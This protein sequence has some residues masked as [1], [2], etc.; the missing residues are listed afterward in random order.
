M[1][2]L[3]FLLVNVL[4]ILEMKFTR[5]LLVCLS[6]FLAF[7]NAKAQNNEEA[8]ALVKAGMQLSDAKKYPEAIEKYQ[9]ALKLDTG[10]LYADFEL[11]YTLL[12][13][14]RGLEGIPYV[15]K[16][17]KQST[18]MLAGAYDLLGSIYDKDKQSS[19]AIAAYQAGIKANPKFQRLYYNLGIAYFRDKKYAEA[20]H[21][22]VDAIKLDPKHASS[23]RMYALVNFHQNKRA[24]AL[25]GL[26]SFI[27]LEPNTARSTE[28]FGNIQHILQ[29]GVLKPD[30]G[31]LPTTTNADN[32]ALNQAITKNIADAAK[33][34]YDNPT[35][36]LAEQLKTIFINIG[37]LAKTQTGDDFFRNYFAAYFY[38]LAQSPNMEVFAQVI[39]SGASKDEYAKWA[40]THSKEMADLDNWLKGTERGF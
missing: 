2:K 15:D 31:E 38:K 25:L 34:K 27:L 32:T 14:G 19:K 28:A 37:G 36:L 1:F 3:F 21:C 26:C 17:I 20:E 33:K 30:P 23:V 29:G 5:F 24:N 22:A 7:D 13:A 39:S 16:V 18:T 10:Y 9:Q 6:F 11:A 12:N 8:R 40:A 35:A 4:I